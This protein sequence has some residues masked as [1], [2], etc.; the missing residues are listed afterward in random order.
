MRRANDVRFPT[1]S[2][3]PSREIEQQRHEDGKTSAEGLDYPRYH[4]KWCRWVLVVVS[5][6]CNGRRVCD[7]AEFTWVPL[8]T[9]AT[10]KEADIGSK[11]DQVNGMAATAAKQQ[12]SSIIAFTKK[13]KKKYC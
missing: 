6:P 5:L 11:D 1:D 13:K 12:Q 8:A 10:Q 4:E 9:N 2:T 3:L 7:A